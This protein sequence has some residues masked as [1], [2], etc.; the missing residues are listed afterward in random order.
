MSYLRWPR[1]H[2]TGLYRA[3][4]STVN[5]NPLNYDTGNT[6]QLAPSFNP[7]GSAEWSMNASVSLVCYK[8]GICNNDHPEVRLTGLW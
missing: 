6:A 5:N 3:D 2:F 1:L 8:N 4:V 7:L